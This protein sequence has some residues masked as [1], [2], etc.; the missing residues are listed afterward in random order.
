MRIDEL[1]RSDNIEDRRGVRMRCGGIGIGTLL[2]LGLIDGTTRGARL[3]ACLLA[4]S[5]S[6]GK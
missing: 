4:S 5:H 6:L 2:V 1:P 3:Q